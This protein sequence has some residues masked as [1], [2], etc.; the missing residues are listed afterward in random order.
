[1]MK[2]DTFSNRIMEATLSTDKKKDKKKLGL[3]G[4][5]IPFKLA[6]AIVIEQKF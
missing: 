5:G 2:A 1:M 6:I 3:L 4:L